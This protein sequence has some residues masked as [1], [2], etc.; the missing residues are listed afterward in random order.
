M[1]IHLQK[2]KPPANKA[3]FQS[4]AWKQI[5]CMLNLATLNI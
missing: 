3:A 1:Y 5:K 2:H 4:K